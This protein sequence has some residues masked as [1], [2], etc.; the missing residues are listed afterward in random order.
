MPPVSLAQS[1]ANIAS[2]WV[3]ILV[4]IGIVLGGAAVIVVL[5]RRLLH[6]RRDEH[7]AGILDQLERMR[8][9]GQLSDEEFRRTRDRVIGRVGGSGEDAS[10]PDEPVQ[11]DDD[12][13]DP[14]GSG[15]DRVP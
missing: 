11:S 9:Q 8:Q 14:P 10:E 15:G 2:L 13:V 4:L 5:R 12:G 7:G 1:S 3:W 6:D